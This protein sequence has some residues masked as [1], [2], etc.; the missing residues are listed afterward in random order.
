MTPRSLFVIIVKVLGIFMLKDVILN[1]SQLIFHLVR[2]MSAS[3]EGYADL[4][5][6]LI[7]LILN[8]A[9]FY[10]FVF[11]P[12][13]V[14]SKLKLEKQFYEEQFMMSMDKYVMINIAVIVAG[15]FLLADGI[16]NLIKYLVVYYQSA[17]YANPRYDGPNINANNIAFT[18]A[19][20]II[21]Y[22]MLTNSNFIAGF[23]TKEKEIE[24]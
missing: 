20:L 24:E 11:R 6:I 2:L 21:A 5:S 22:V 8:F 9:I 3:Y 19:K 1:C 18:V 14:I 13:I 7:S 4:V 15:L 23:V 12:D 17:S 16:P 10:L